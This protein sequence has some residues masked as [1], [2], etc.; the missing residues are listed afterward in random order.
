MASFVVIANRVIKGFR[1]VQFRLKAM[2]RRQGRLRIE[3]DSKHTV[4]RQRKILREVGSRCCLPEPPLKFT[5]AN[6]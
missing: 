6:I 4:S 3:I 2:Q 5:T 1:L